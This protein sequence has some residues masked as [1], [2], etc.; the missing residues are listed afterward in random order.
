MWR[1]VKS[2]MVGYVE[3]VV[4]ISS[5]H[6]SLVDKEKRNRML[7]RNVKGGFSNNNRE[8]IYHQKDH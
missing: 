6:K 8:F 3:R 1:V 7:A 5:E 2:R 4:E